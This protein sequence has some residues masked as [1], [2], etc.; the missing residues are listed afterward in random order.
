M[1]DRVL[2]LAELPARLRVRY[3]QLIIERD[4]LPEVTVPLNEIAA[5]IVSHP[6]ISLTH[7]VLSGLM[8]CGGVI[9][10]CDDQC[11][12]AGM[13]LPIET[14]V[15][16]TRR[17]AAQA[18]APAPTNKRLWQQIVR[19][20][21]RAQARLLQS[22][23]GTDGGLLDLVGEVRSGDPQNIEAQAA[24]RYWPLLFNDPG[25]LRRRDAQDQNRL[26]NYGYAVLRAIVARAVCAA[27]LHPSIGMHHRNQYNAFCLADDLMEPYRPLVDRIVLQVVAQRGSDVPIDKDS[28][29]ALLELLAVRYSWQGESRTMF[30]WMSR[31]ASSLAQVY[32][33]EAKRLE[34]PEL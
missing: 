19:T 28:K 6:Q 21:I 13:M 2:D 33:G 8:R 32:A 18:A 29:R 5:V 30:D 9:I 16:Q 24:A 23:C 17:M 12:P 15:L 22:K 31:T 26:L 10:C 4:G 34:L 1:P 7:S 27:G 14:H 11:L 20:K 3:E 25:F